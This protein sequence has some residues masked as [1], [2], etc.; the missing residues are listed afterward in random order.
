MLDAYQEGTVDRVYLVYNN[1]VNSMTQQAVSEQ[2][3]LN[4]AQ[5]TR[6][7]NRQPGARLGPSNLLQ[8]LV[9]LKNKLVHL[10]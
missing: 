7:L 4:R 10:H 5:L 9:L 1:F 6:R 3:L 8:H 2:L